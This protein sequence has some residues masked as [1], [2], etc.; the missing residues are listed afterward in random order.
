ARVLAD[1][2]QHAL[3]QCRLIIVLLGDVPLGVP[4][5]AH[6]FAGPSLGDC[7]AQCLA[8]M[9][10]SLASLRRA[11]A[12]PRWSNASLRICLSSARS[13]TARLSRWFSCWSSLSCLA[14]SAFM[15]PY[16]WRQR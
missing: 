13:A 1:Q 8:H 5:L 14:A 6:D 3:N 15:P 12:F 11:Y 10:D 4:G 7:F 9:R 2:F 16:C